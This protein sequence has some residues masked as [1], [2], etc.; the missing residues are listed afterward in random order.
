MTAP[1]INSIDKDV[2]SDECYR[3]GYNLT[4]IADEQPCPECGLLAQRSRRP[5]DE[6]HDTRPRWLKSISRG[7]NLVCLAILLACAWPFVIGPLEHAISEALRPRNRAGWAAASRTY[8]EW[9]LSVLPILGF[10]VAALVFVAG[11]VLLTR[12]ERYPPADR[13]DRRARVLLRILA[14]VPIVAMLLIQI[15]TV[16]LYRWV[17]AGMNYDDRFHLA[18]MA[19]LLATLGAVPLPLVLALRFRSL[20]RRVRSV[21]LAE[22]CAIVGIGTSA[23]ILYLMGAGYV[24][25]HADGWGWGTNWAGR[26]QV[27]LVITLVL[28]TAGTLFVLWSLYLLVRFA[29]A[30]RHAAR[31]LRQ[32]WTRDDRAAATLA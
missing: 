29:I 13:A 1:P 25:A 8:W 7:T 5:S 6:L 18:T 23:S 12:P 9:L 4:G 2:Q 20:A 14:I 11:V 15:D 17:R 19:F 10:E 32:K 16:L 28:A 24:L 3:C 30:F 31:Q 26:S 27:A 21:H 22:H